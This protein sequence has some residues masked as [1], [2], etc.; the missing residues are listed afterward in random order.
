MS[1]FDNY[2]TPIGN[3]LAIIIF[4]IYTRIALCTYLAFTEPLSLTFKYLLI[5]IFFIPILRYIIYKVTDN[6]MVEGSNMFV[7]CVIPILY[8]FLFV[9]VASVYQFRYFILLI[10][11]FLPALIHYKFI[12]ATHTYPDNRVQ[13]LT[14]MCYYIIPFL[15]GINY[16]FDFS[17]PAVNKYYIFATK[18]LTHIDNSSE[19]ITTHDYYLDLV[20]ATKTI[21]PA[22]WVEV[23]RKMSDERSRQHSSNYVTDENETYKIFAKKKVADTSK[24]RN[25]FRLYPTSRFRYYFLLQKDMDFERTKVTWKVYNRFKRGDYVFKETHYGLLGFSWITYR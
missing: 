1:F 9:Q 5:I 11:L 14:T 10:L 21:E 23:S 8:A 3:F 25:N 24:R 12:I 4:S 7:L 15:L 2:L 13:L 22:K 19:G 16:A 17:K 20:P 18:E 6:E